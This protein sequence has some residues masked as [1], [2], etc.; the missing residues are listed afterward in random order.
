MMAKIL[1]G[2]SRAAMR[3]PGASIQLAVDRASLMNLST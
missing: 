1:I 2:W 3:F